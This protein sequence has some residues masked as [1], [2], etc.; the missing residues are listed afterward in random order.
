MDIRQYSARNK[1]VHLLTY[2]CPT[3]TFL[4]VGHH[5]FR[6]IDSNLHDGMFRPFHEM[7]LKCKANKYSVQR[8]IAVYKEHVCL[9]S[10]KC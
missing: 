6:A 1:G 2:G 8:H 7:Q 5:K 3:G 10:I 4:S 9:R